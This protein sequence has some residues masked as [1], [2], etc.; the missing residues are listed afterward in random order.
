L[1]DLGWVDPNRLVAQGASAGGLL[2]GAILNLAP[3]LY[4]AVHADVP[5]V[6]ALTTMLDPT[7]PLT[8]GEWE[9]WGNPIADPEVY[10]YMK[11]YAPYENVRAV[12]YPAILATTSL[13]DTRVF[14]VEP[15][16]WVQQLRRTVTS[17]SERPVLL[18]IEMAAG[19]GGRSGRY[20]G[21]R[22]TAFEY[23]FLLDR[24]GATAPSEWPRS[25]AGR[26]SA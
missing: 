19:H 22:Q 6:D 3:E 24:V 17:G 14:Y 10:A 12:R 21:W 5:F 9:E 2:M 7:L 11:S 20:D 16:K 25:R 15:A 23:A 1:L 26:F 18:K 13:Q 4:A 8:A